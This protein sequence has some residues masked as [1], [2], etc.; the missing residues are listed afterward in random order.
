MDLTR[1]NFKRRRSQPSLLQRLH[2]R[3]TC[4]S[5]P[6]TSCLQS[7]KFYQNIVP[8][9]TVHNVEV[10]NCHIKKFTSDGEVCCLLH[11]LLSSL[12]TFTSSISKTR[13]ILS[14][15]THLVPPI[16]PARHFKYSSLFLLLASLLF[17]KKLPRHSA[18]PIQRSP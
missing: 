15:P 9:Y 8:N 7:R 2:A 5:K 1:C 10:P 16:P 6:S 11:K 18:V 14:T 4:R 13:I 3:E 17:Y 12:F